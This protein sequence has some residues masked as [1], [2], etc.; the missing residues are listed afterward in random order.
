MSDVNFYKIQ[1]TGNDFIVVDFNSAP[2][3]IFDP[4]TI[5]KICH[6][7]FGIGAD[8]LIAL[9][10]SNPFVFRFHY[11]NSD[12]SR[13][14][15]CG[16]GCRAA[17]CFA[18]EQKW[19][20]GNESFEFVADDGVHTGQVISNGFKASISVKETINK[21]S[22]NNFKLPGWV[23]EIYSINTGVPH[24]VLICNENLIKKEICELG[25]YL[26]FHDLFKPQGTN[27]NFVEMLNDSK[28]Y[29]RTYERGVEGETL[30]CGT[31]LTAAALVV[32]SKNNL[33]NK[34]EIVTNGGDLH[35]AFNDDKIYINGP[36]ELTY[37][38]IIKV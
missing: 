14:E 2:D 21:I 8:G 24:L 37:Q 31:G 12:G 33:I 20:S 25:K 7:N 38:G 9:E 5:Q 28:I 35:V 22:Q 26:R 17:I 36:A 4:V 11:Y 19:I 3:R 23:K 32:K 15:M 6:R 27:V 10:K 29:I 34:V 18:R 1:A 30:S 13:A 16:N